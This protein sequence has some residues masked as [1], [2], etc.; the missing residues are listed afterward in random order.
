MVWRNTNISRI[1]IAKKLDLYRSTITNIISSLIEN[2]LIREGV[3]G[4]SSAK[5]GRPPVSLYINRNFGCIIGIDL[6]PETYSVVII[7]VDGTPLMSFTDKT[8][9]SEEY[10]DSSEKSFIFSMDHI[11]ASL[12]EPVSRLN[13]PVLG[14]CICVPGIVDIDKGIIKDSDSFGLRDFPFSETFYSRYGVPCTVE[15]DARCLAWKHFALQRGDNVKKEDFICVLAKNMEGINGH[16]NCLPRMQE[17]ESDDW[18]VAVLT[19]GFAI[20]VA[21]AIAAIKLLGK[22]VEK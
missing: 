3:V 17:E 8:P 9:V 18:A 1:E 2:D 5:G 7:S 4:T 14:M 10:R 13:A 6:H 19:T 22:F 16:N 21:A 11:I 12:L 15:N 20:G